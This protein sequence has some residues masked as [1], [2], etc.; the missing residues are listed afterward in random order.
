MHSL[1]HV[2][3]VWPGELV[4]GRSVNGGLTSDGPSA[5]DGFPQARSTSIGSEGAK[6]ADWP[7]VQPARYDLTVNVKTAATLGLTIPPSVPLRGDDVV[8]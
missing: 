8:L 1:E 6:P 2:K 5:E 3:T 4:A 7:A